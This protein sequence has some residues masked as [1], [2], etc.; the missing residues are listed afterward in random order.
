MTIQ[1]WIL[2]SRPKTL[3]AAV[4]PVFAATGLVHAHDGAL[5]LW[6]VAACL[7]CS[8]LIQIA[9]NFI[10]DVEDFKRG[11]DDEHRLGPV[12][13]TQAKLLTEQQLWRA[14]LLLLL[15]AL[16]LGIPLV[17]HGG[18]PILLIG[19][20][21]LFLGYAYTGGPFPLAYWGLGELFVILFFGVIPVSGVYFLLEGQWDRSAAILGL[22]IGLHCSILIAINNLR[23]VVNDKKA[24]RKT[25][26]VLFGIQYGKLIIH[27]LIWLPYFIGIY[28]FP[29]LTNL[30]GL[31]PY[32][33]L[34]LAV[35]LTRNII[36]TAP[37]AS[38]NKFLGKA[39]L[40]HLSFGFLTA[41]GMFICRP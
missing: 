39:A 26:P 40:L 24:G 22:Q 1:N 25:G 32:L 6:I 13:A 35:S 33:T 18:W 29:A 36:A 31:L 23:D 11:A 15:A 17:L 7:A 21:S 28:W 27:L 37:S 41:I 19:L 4:V 20:L 9:T 12:R 38:Y 34:P 2:A 14:A 10:N 5:I 30:C 3:T 8:L 16:V